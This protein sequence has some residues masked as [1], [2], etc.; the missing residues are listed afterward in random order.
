MTVCAKGWLVA[1]AL[2]SGCGAA[3]AWE[4]VAPLQRARAAHAV[5]AVEDGLIALA[6]TGSDGAPVREVERFD[7]VAWQMETEIPGPGLNAPA[8][9]A[10]DGAVYLLGGFDMTTNIPRAGV[11]VYDL[12]DRRWSEGV[13]LPAARGGHA[14]V[15]LAGQIH[16]V[17]GGNSER[18][19]AE[20]DVYDPATRTWTARAEL[21]RAAGSVAAVVHEGKLF[22]I[23]GRSGPGDF[24]D[25]DVYD[26]ATNV[27]TSGPRIG[28]RGTAGAA[29]VCGAVVVFGGETQAPAAVLGEVLRLGGEGWR[30]MAPLPTARSFARAVTWRGAVYVVG[31][32]VAPQTDHAPEGSAAVE[33][34]RCG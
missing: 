2:A 4:G 9:V 19:L 15:V 33:R 12:K 31:G 34:L 20:H 22:A 21:P 24:G 7:G 3:P 28:P 10:L 5:V 17:G 32:G 30:G 26:P 23:G 27:W 25:V 29:V 6:G 18:T 16:V 14:A 11:D 13:A 1:L 8:A